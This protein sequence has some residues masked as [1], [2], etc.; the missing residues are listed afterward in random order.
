VV[1]DVPKPQTPNAPAAAQVVQVS[2][3]DGLPFRVALAEDVP[4]DAREGQ[5]VSFRVLDDLKVGDAV[6]IARGATVAGTIVS[7][8]GKKKFLG[9][10]GK[11]T[12]Q[13]NSVEGP[14]GQK[15]KVRAAAARKA[16]GPTVRPID[17]GKY[18]KA[19]DLAAARGTDYIAYVDGEQTISVHK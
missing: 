14:D 13:L 11:M 7:E 4:A 16:D 9:F 15:V 1:K 18:A 8:T 10:G 5:T 6:V 3:S 12:Y 19:K 17:T 2:V